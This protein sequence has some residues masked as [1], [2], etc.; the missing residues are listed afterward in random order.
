MKALIAALMITSPALADDLVTIDF[1]NQSSRDVDAISVY[2]VSDTGE[3]IDDNIG[4]IIDPIAPGDIRRL[5]LAL[6]R[7]GKVWA[8]ASFEGGEEVTG[9]TDLCR[10]QRLILTD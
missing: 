2:P 4:T 6:V 8:R 5:D 10:N 1:D 9:Q 3:V 7:C